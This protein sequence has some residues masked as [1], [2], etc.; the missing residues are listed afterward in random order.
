MTSETSWPRIDKDDYFSGLGFGSGS[1][2]VIKGATNS[3]PEKALEAEKEEAVHMALRLSDEDL[4]AN[5]ILQSYR[6][7]VQGLGRSAKRF[8]PS[9]ESLHRSVRRTGRLPRISSVVD[10]YNI[11]ALAYFVAFGVHDLAQLAPPI[12]FRRSPGGELF[13]PVGSP[14]HKS[15]QAGDYVYADEIRVLAWLDSRDSDEAKVSMATTD[16]LVVIQ[17][18]AATSQDYTLEAIND[19]CSRIVKYCGGSFEAR[20]LWR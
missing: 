11:S 2:A 13:Q 18:T 8:P 17:G 6:S 19:A 9:A 16:I 5:A 1:V 4:D 15:T 7:A 12:Q 20:P 10:S 14:D 3:E